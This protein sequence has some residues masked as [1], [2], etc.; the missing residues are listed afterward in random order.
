MINKGGKVI[1]PKM[2][3]FQAAATNAD[4]K[5]APGY[6]LMLADQ[7]GEGSWPITAASFIDANR[8]ARRS[9]LGEAL[10]FFDWADRSGDE[11][12]EAL[13]YVPMPDNVVG[14]VQDEWAKIKDPGGNPISRRTDVPGH[15]RAGQ[16]QRE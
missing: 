3:S 7:P 2:E 6:G 13:D 10:D 8:C 14:L 12:A 16:V 15:G 1:A 4:W 9:G 11:L 5:S